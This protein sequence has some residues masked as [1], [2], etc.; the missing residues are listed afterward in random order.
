MG[1]ESRQPASI[2]TG[3]QILDVGCGIG[4]TSRYLAADR[5]CRVAGIDLTLEYVEVARELTARCGL[6]ER[7]EF[8]QGDALDMPFEDAA[9]DHAIWHFVTMNI[10]DK[11]G[12]MAE[13]ARIFKPGRRFSCSEIN[14]GPAGEPIYPLPW[15]RDP[16]SSFLV[17][18]E[19]TRHPGRGWPALDRG[20][21]PG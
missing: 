16:S 5:G 4:G 20:A 17:S 10:E 11:A 8:H 2:E 21:E 7:I 6:S 12:L 14:L 19:A 1:A 15:A 3:M 9:F 18:P 13:I